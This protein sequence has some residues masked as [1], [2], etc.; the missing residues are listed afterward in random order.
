MQLII[1]FLVDVPNHIAA[2]SKLLTDIP[3]RLFSFIGG[4]T[5]L[6]RVTEMEVIVGEPLP[7]ARR[8]HHC[9]DLSE[10]E[11]FDFITWFE[12][13]PSDEVRFNNLLA[14]DGLRPPLKDTQLPNRIFKLRILVFVIVMLVLVL[15]AYFYGASPP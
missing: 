12:Y 10:N 8:L 2:A 11:P 3:A 4:E 5:G 13:A 6:W 1:G 15:L 7:A 9:R 14:A